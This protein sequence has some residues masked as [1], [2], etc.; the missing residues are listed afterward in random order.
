MSLRWINHGRTLLCSLVFVATSFIVMAVPWE[1]PPLSTMTPANAENDA[2]SDDRS[3]IFMGVN[4]RGHYTNLQYE[5]YSNIHFPM[6]YYDE[7]FRQIRDA[8]LNLVRYLFYW[9][10]YEKNPELFMKELKTVANVA[11]RYGIKVIYDNHQYQT[12]SWLDPK[13]GTGFPPS[14]F[15]N[16]DGQYDRGSGGKTHH[17]S[18]KLWW[19]KWW[20]SEI[21]DTDGRDGWARI[22]DFLIQIVKTVDNHPSTL[23]YEMLN[24]PQIHSD[25]QWEKVGKFNSYLV[26]ELRKTTQKIIVFSQQIP[27]SKDTEIIELTPRNIAKMAPEDKN[28]ILFKFTLYRLPEPG[29]YHEDRFKTYLAAG[30]IVGIPVMIGEWNNVERV[31]VKEAN[32]DGDK[33]EIYKIDTKTSDIDQSRASFFVEMFEKSQIWG[34]AYWNWNY[35][36]SPITPVNLLTVTPDGQMHPTKY[37]EILKNAVSEVHG[38]ESIE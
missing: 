18:S 38:I 27:G 4:V 10:A 36:P 30:E 25:D 9:E 8:G 19:T 35:I 16:G 29:S 6:N 20:D 1:E 5:R 7:S 22:A 23:G 2:A 33:I 34:W 17:E 24:E 32:R 14:L 37:F 3:P 31:K 11:D 15:Q 13:N 28:N 26:K 21:E 12:S